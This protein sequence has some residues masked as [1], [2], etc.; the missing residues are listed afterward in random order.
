MFK[1][2]FSFYGRIGRTEYAISFIIY[3]VFAVIVNEIMQSGSGT[4][5][6]GLA[7]IPMLWFFWA[8]GTKRC[9]DLGNSGWWQLVPFYVL[10]LLFAAGASGANEYGESFQGASETYPILDETAA[11]KNMKI[12]DADSISDTVNKRLTEVENQS[13]KDNLIEL[14]GLIKMQ[15]K[16]TFGG[17]VTKEIEG[18]LNELARSKQEGIVLINCYSALFKKDLINDLEKM[19]NS[20][21]GIRQNVSFLLI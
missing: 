17:K 11:T 2:P 12:E 14:N 7:Y 16:K 10:W 18:L 5:V 3:V 20:Y 19:N 13:Y 8:Q 15:Q 9:H 6:I 4:S 1:N 21:D